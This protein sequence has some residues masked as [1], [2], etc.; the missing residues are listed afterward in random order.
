MGQFLVIGIASSIGVSKQKAMTDFKGIKNFKAV[1]EKE[2]NKSG[3]YQCVETEDYVQFE[4]KP[5]IAAREWIDFIRSFY[6]LRYT[7]TSWDKYETKEILEELSEKHDLDDWLELAENKSHQ[8]YQMAEFYFYPINNQFSFYGWTNV[9]MDMVVLSLDGK[10]FME[11][12]D[13]LFKFF[14]QLIREKLSYFQ[15]ADSLQISITE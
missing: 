13:N 15:L 6:K 3:I 5:E 9:E 1:I 8:C 7:G 11:C 10:V 12:Y 2:L 4:L 14:L